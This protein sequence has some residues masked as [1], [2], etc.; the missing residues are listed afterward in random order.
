MK[1]RIGIVIGLAVVALGLWWWRSR[2]LETATH[3]TTSTGSAR[4]ASLATADVGVV[5]RAKVDPRTQPTASFAGTVRDKAGAP[6]AGAAVCT[7]IFSSE[8]P[9]DIWPERKCQKTNAQGAYAFTELFA[10]E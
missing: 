10:A 2:A 6:I 1:R 9:P 7:M 3:G 5:P 8:L 4:T